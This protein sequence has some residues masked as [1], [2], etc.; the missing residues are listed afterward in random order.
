MRWQG[1]R[2]AP[3]VRCDRSTE[4]EAGL[5]TGGCKSGEFIVYY[6]QRFTFGTYYA[7]HLVLQASETYITCW[8]P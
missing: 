4:Q 8:W 3:H 1:G 6:A 7:V 2:G 5:V